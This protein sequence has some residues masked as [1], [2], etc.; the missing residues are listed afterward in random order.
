MK[1][2][3]YFIYATLNN[4]NTQSIT[5][6]EFEYNNKTKVWDF[7]YELAK[8]YVEINY[9]GATE[10]DQ[11]IETIPF[12]I[13]GIMNTPIDYD[14]GNILLFKYCEKMLDRILCIIP[15]FAIG[16]L[17]AQ[18][19]NYK[20]VIHSNEDNHKYFPHI[21]INSVADCIV[22]D[23]KTL[24]QV[25]GFPITGKAKKKI[26]KYLKDN[27]N[28]LIQLYDDIVNKKIVDKF[29]KTIIT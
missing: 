27:Q 24:K 28:Y 23:L 9:N 11:I 10:I 22:I 4:I 6:E 2:L 3:R 16:G 12:E 26:F 13:I 14:H 7:Y 1:K 25:E 15:I 21:H 18:Y 5:I 8:K 29:E 17:V 19:N 20:L